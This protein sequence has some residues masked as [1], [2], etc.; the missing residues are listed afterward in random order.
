MPLVMKT[1]AKVFALLSI[2]TAASAHDRVIVGVLTAE[3]SRVIDILYQYENYVS[4]LPAS[5]VKWV[6]FEMIF[7]S[8]ILKFLFIKFILIL[9]VIF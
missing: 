5:Y 6:S 8:K 3:I 1:A 2:F 7:E 4:F 9:R